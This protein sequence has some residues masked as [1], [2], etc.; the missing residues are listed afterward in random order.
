MTTDAR[1]ADHAP[2]RFAV[3]ETPA[4]GTVV[5]VAPG[6]R[7][8]RIPLPYRLDHVNVYLIEDNGGWTL[9]DTGIQTPAAQE[10][11]ESLLA[12]PLAGI[13]ITRVVISHCHPDHIGLAGWFCSRFDA[14]LLTSY[15]TYAASKM[16]S[17]DPH[18]SASE[19]SQKFYQRYGMAPES[20][21]FVATT[22][23]EYLRQVHPL[24]ETFLR[25][26]MGDALDIGGRRFRVMSGDGHAPEQVM[27]YCPEDGLFLAADQVMERI[28]PNVSI[29]AMEPNSD[30]L[31]HYMRSLKAL[32]TRIPDRTLVLAG[33]HRPFYGLA[34]RSS[35]IFAH[36][37][38]RCQ[39][40]LEACRPGPKSV[41][42]LVPVM[43]RGRTFNAHEMSF[44]F[45]ETM[46]HVNRLIRRGELEWDETTG[47][48][49][50]RVTGA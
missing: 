12:G 26:L 6:I 43:F 9:F 17:L 22:G 35:E 23:L 48:P 37:E 27:L 3:E 31:G 24:P 44:A 14:P 41:D 40:I 8:A 10:V 29:W 18:S 2:I 30:A 16:M 21:Q 33:H 36:H 28:T 1:S 5:E 32:T 42:E 39:L 47:R 7:W 38:D 34:R 20:A 13:R 11:W 19:Q 25:L 15:S 50:C 4:F 46:A 45:T 49:L